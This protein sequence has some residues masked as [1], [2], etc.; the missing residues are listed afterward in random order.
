MYFYGFK[1]DT[2][3][4]NEQ[5]QCLEEN[6]GIVK[7]AWITE[8]GWGRASP[9]GNAKYYYPSLW[10]IKIGIKNGHPR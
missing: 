9:K 7:Y 3:E 5:G 8:L 2:T 1:S 10:E 6:N 4:K